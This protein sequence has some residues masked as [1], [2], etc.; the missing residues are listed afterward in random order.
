MHED[1][2]MFICQLR[3]L[4]KNS[5]ATEMLSSYTNNEDEELHL[6]KNLSA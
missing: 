1:L 6:F 2:I 3:E 4:D 5:S